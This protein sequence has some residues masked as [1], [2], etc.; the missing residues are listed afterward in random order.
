MNKSDAERLASILDTLGM[1]RTQ[2][3][4]Q[5]SLIAVQ[6]C[7]VRQSAIDRIHA[8][9]NA[10]KKRKGVLTL[11]SGCVLPDDKKTFKKHFDIVLDTHDLIKLPEELY[12][13]SFLSHK[14][15]NAQ[16]H[17]K[18]D[19]ITN[20]DFFAITP[21]YSSS[22]KAWVPIQSGCNN[23][24]T[25]CAVPYTKGREKYRSHTS[26]MEEIEKL[27]RKGY[28]D[29]TLLGQN[30]NTYFDPTLKDG[31][32]KRL[33][34][35]K[36]NALTDFPR[37]LRLVNSIEGDFW[38]R[39]VTSNPWD[40]SEETIKAVA[41]SEKICEYIHLPVQAG[42]NYTLKRMNR[43]HGVSHY[44]KLLHTIRAK[45]PAPLAITTDIIVGF[46][47]ETRG[48]FE[49]TADLMRYANFDMA[50]IAKYSKRPN[51]IAC[52]KFR[53]DVSYEEKKYREK[54]LTA[55]LKKSALENN[56]KL[57]GKTMRVL[58]EKH[59]GNNIYTGKTRTFKNVRFFSNK[60]AAG[61]FV[62]VKIENCSAWG[63]KG[64][65]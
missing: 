44:K 14:D 63:L 47:G 8:R 29:I 21:N 13:L 24:C 51:T 50:Y 23:F 4:E 39:F 9:I 11:L 33:K 7:S 10:W 53:D 35:R 55:I 34:Y 22:F 60:N 37:L 2:N 45:I 30:V 58:A 15:A 59:L 12:K 61:H 19:S 64:A 48:H 16:E 46:P 6:A 36:W 62:D 54:I 18:A 40:M 56:K 17:I 41:D 5:A 57:I 26:I 49:G 31:V 43:H 3:E 20:D 52:Q 27:V 28:K 42:H 25:Y 38:I 65:L 1:E 32:G